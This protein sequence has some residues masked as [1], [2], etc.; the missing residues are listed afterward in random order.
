[1]RAGIPAV[2]LIALLA[3]AG[4]GGAGSRTAPTKAQFTVRADAICRLE[5]VKLHRAAAVD[6]TS[7]A[8]FREI[9]RLIRRAVAIHGAANAKLE[10]LPK[11]VG[12]DATIT[13][14][15]TARTVATTLELDTAE[16]PAG[17]DSI[18]ATDIRIALDRARAAVRSLSHRY[19]FRVC[20]ETE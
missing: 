8:S 18:A 13:R 15:L 9:P 2:G 16:A 7:L 4:C 1:V 14:W 10:A 11:P 6:D 12:E 3:L 20:G 17:A 19:G 5:S